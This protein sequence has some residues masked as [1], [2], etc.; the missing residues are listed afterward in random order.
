MA[1]IQKVDDKL[2]D[3]CNAV[4]ATSILVL[5]ASELAPDIVA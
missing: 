1:G 4:D 3:D 5:V 2:L